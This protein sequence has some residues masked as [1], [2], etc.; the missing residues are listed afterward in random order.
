M[1]DGIVHL[2]RF[3][4]ERCALDL[5]ASTLEGILG[6][7]K[8]VAGIELDAGLIGIHLKKSAACFLIHLCTKHG[9]IGLSAHKAIAMIIASRNGEMLNFKFGLCSKFEFRK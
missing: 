5:R 7:T 6:G 8:E 4:T 9:R 1:V 2:L 3:Q